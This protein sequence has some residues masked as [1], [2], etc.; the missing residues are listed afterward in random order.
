MPVLLYGCENWILT[1][2][3]MHQLESFLGWMAKRALKWPQHFSTSAAL[4]SLGME[5]MKSRILTRKLGFLL[6]LLSDDTEG[7]VAS[8]LCALLDNPGST[9]IVQ[10]CHELESTYGLKCTDTILSDAGSVCLQDIKREVLSADKA[11]LL[12]KCTAKSPLIAEIPKQGGSWP[13]LWDTV[14]HLGSRHTVGLQHISRMLAHHGRG[15]KPCPLCN[16]QLSGSSLSDHVIMLHK[17]KIQLPHLT[18]RSLLSQLVDRNV[19][20]VYRFRHLFNPTHM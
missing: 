17:E 13:A 9:C 15:S 19:T 10:E 12:N 2:R 6:H 3:S 8:T 1:D 5:T 4:V 7:V 18:P 16:D 11:F 14:R 20:F